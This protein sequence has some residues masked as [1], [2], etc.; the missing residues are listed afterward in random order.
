MSGIFFLQGGHHF[1]DADKM[2]SFRAYIIR[3]TFAAMKPTSDEMREFIRRE[4]LRHGQ[5]LSARFR[6]N[7]ERNRNVSSGELIDAIAMPR[8]TADDTLVF[9][10]PSYGRFFEIEGRRRRTTYNRLR[11]ENGSAWMKQ[12]GFARVKKTDW[13]AKTMYRGLGRLVSR[14][15]AGISE[16]ELSDIRSA[17]EYGVRD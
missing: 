13:Y 8:L 6:E 9:E 12:N 17:L 14:L 10:L 2:M 15:S 5:W 16:E 7:L 1:A 3:C 11:R 4:L